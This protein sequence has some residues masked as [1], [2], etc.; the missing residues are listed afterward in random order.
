M[1]AAASTSYASNGSNASTTSLSSS[2][3]TSILGPSS[4]RQFE[5]KEGHHHQHQHHHPQSRLANVTYPPI[6]ALAP[7]TPVLTPLASGTSSSASTPRSN[8]PRARFTIGPEE[9]GRGGRRDANEGT[10]G[11]GLGR[12]SVGGAGGGVSIS[13]REPSSS[14]LWEFEEDE[15]RGRV[16]RAGVRGRRGDVKVLQV[17]MQ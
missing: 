3:T 6:P 4:R 5:G 14:E 16:G 11:R 9:R 12:K 1:G 17:L 10:R 2:S 7:L 8:H 15:E 13:R